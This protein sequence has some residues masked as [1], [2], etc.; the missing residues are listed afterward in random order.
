MGLGGWRYATASGG[1]ELNL[2]RRFHAHASDGNF[3]YVF[4]G[5]VRTR[6]DGKKPALKRML[7]DLIV[8]DAAANRWTSLHPGPQIRSLSRPLSRVNSQMG[9]TP[10]AASGGSAGGGGSASDSIL[11]CPCKRKGAAMTYV[12]EK[13]ALVLFGGAG[14]SGCLNDL[15]IFELEKNRG[16]I[17]LG[18]I[19][20][21]RALESSRQTH[22]NFALNPLGLARTQAAWTDRPKT[23]RAALTSVTGEGG[24]ASTGDSS[25]RKVSSGVG[26][27]LGVGVGVGV[28]SAGCAAA[29]LKVTAEYA[30]E[31]PRAYPAPRSYHGLFA[32]NQQIVVV[33]GYGLRE[34]DVGNG[35]SGREKDRHEIEGRLFV[36]RDRSGERDRLLACDLFLLDLKPWFNERQED[37]GRQENTGRQESRE[38]EDGETFKGKQGGEKGGEGEKGRFSKRGEGWNW[39]WKRIPGNPEV[40][41]RFGSFHCVFEKGLFTFGGQCNNKLA[42]RTLWR[43]DLET[44]QWSSVPYVGTPPRSRTYGASCLVKNRWFMHGGSSTDQVFRDAFEIDLSTFEWTPAESLASSITLEGHSAH[45]CPLPATNE[46]ANVSPSSGLSVLHLFGGATSDATVPDG[47][48]LVAALLIPTSSHSSSASHSS[49]SPRFSHPSSLAEQGTANR[50]RLQGC[51]ESFVVSPPSLAAALL[52]RSQIS[53]HNLVPSPASPSRASLAE[54]SEKAKAKDSAEKARETALEEREGILEKQEKEL[55]E[56][57]RLLTFRTKRVCQRETEIQAGSERLAA[58]A[59]RERDIYKR[60]ADVEEA[61][62]GLK[63][64]EAELERREDLLRTEEARL[65]EYEGHL[66]RRE[67]DLQRAERERGNEERRNEELR[68]EELEALSVRLRNE[69]V[70]LDEERSA[71]KRRV[72][73]FEEAALLA[74]QQSKSPLSGSMSASMSMSLSKSRSPGRSGGRGRE[75]VALGRKCRELGRKYAAL[76]RAVDAHTCGVTVGVQVGANEM[77]RLHAPRKENHAPLAR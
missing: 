67:E 18:L 1:E 51:L 58:L 13:R 28:G 29:D 26:V 40:G 52:G 62:T 27:G 15:W 55:A 2:F 22:A 73:E 56:R 30:A 16:W 46:S 57:E 44:F 23:K 41:C 47:P 61:E 19:I 39:N 24:N 69:R 45:F 20:V 12:V 36:R 63:S 6:G 68:S 43:L 5:E 72:A 8:L 42:D 59:D 35:N 38:K 65:R 34:D 10:D 70:W 50:G 77:L 21:E 17:D 71:F 37:N 31:R 76:K 54:G 49:H 3:L 60:A 74:S 32:Y 25:R 7:G 11:S 9:S 48:L 14:A 64:Q 4:G 33:G 75:D 66:S 53:D